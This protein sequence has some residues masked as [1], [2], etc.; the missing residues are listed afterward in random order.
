MVRNCGWMVWF[1]VAVMVW[2][3]RAGGLR[4]VFIGRIAVVVRRFGESCRVRA[5]PGCAGRGSL[6]DRPAVGR[7]TAAQTSVMST[8]PIR[9]ASPAT[10]RCRKCPVTMDLAASRM[11][12][13]TLMTVGC[14]VI[15]VRI[16]RSLTSLPSA[17]AWTMSASVMMPRGCLAWSSS[18]TTRAVTPACFIRYA[19]AATWACGSIVAGAGRMTSAAVAGACGGR[20]MEGFWVK[21]SVMIGSVSV[22]PARFPSSVSGPY[23][24]G[25]RVLVCLMTCGLL[26]ISLPADRFGWRRAHS[27]DEGRPP[28][29]WPAGRCGVMMLPAFGRGRVRPGT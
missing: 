5:V 24:R 27:P 3:L 21:G 9:P 16:R 25:P 10:G 28:Q 15:R 19:A 20:C 11:L 18:T 1:V 7:A 8:I 12:V 23:R 2:L 17:T 26:R 4:G 6:A 13:P 14:V 29:A 22:A